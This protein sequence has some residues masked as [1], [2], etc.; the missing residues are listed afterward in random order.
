M[1]CGRVD[2]RARAPRRGAI[3]ACSLRAAR[4][5]RSPSRRCRF[6]GQRARARAAR[7]E[8]D[9][10]VHDRLAQ[11]RCAAA[12]GAGE[13]R[14]GAR[15]RDSG[16]RAIRRRRR[17][18]HARRNPSAAT[19]VG[20][21]LRRAGVIIA[22]CWNSASRRSSPTCSGHCSAASCSGAC[23]ASTFAASAAATPAPRTRCARK[24]SCSRCRCSS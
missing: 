12:P 24:A 23:A 3:H 10:A 1:I 8:A 2:R 15:G 14:R 17:A 19:P 21:P 16:H 18:L 4:S 13:A 7:L 5:S 6:R 22:A 20:A 9:R 11:P